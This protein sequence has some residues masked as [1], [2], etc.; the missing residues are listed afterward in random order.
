MEARSASKGWKRRWE[1][2][3]GNGEGSGKKK[4]RGTKTKLTISKLDEW[5]LVVRGK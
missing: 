3:R 2:D 4:E 1:N 5:M